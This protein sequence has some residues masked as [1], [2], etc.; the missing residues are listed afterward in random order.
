MTDVTPVKRATART[1]RRD[2]LL[3]AAADLVAEIGV[4]GFTMEGL[5][6]A[7]GVSKALPYRHFANSD[8]AL[9]ALHDRELTHLASIILSAVDGLSDGDEILREAIRAYF[10]AVELRG[11]LLNALAGSGSP[12]PAM[13]SAPATRPGDLV[14][15]LLA[16]G[17][18]LRGKGARVLA[19]LV[20]AMAIAGSDSLGRGDAARSTVER[21]TV[22]AAQ[23]AVRAVMDLSAGPKVS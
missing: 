12:V 4:V 7:A 6:S 17:Y 9:V 23:G 21:T 18:G 5:A 19:G 2:Q 8:A 16:R 3:D 22:A 1:D 20:T 14:T 11:D 13:A 15:T 10:D